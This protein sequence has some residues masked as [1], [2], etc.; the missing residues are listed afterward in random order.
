MKNNKI[1]KQGLVVVAT[2]T[3]LFGVSFVNAQTSTTTKHQGQK[4]LNQSTLVSK[5]N[6][7]IDKRVSDLTNLIGTLSSMKN[8]SSAEQSSLSGSIQSEISNLNNLKTKIAGDTD[9]TSLKNDVKSVTAD[10]RI[11]ALVIPQTRILAASDRATTVI[12]MITAMQTKLQSR[13]SDAQ[14][15]GK[16]VS[17]TTQ[18]LN[19]LGIKLAD[20]TNLNNSI[21][22]AISGL[23]PDQGNKTTLASN[24]AAL[25]AAR[26]N[27]TAIQSDLVAARKDIKT[28]M[29]DI[30]GVGSAAN[31]PA[32]ANIGTPSSSGTSSVNQ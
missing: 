17:N 5:A 10:N 18:S 29:S 24:T 30:K 8:I 28:I 12:N 23:T 31:T 11:Y 7:E 15:A 6:T 9:L 19:D 25:K 14:S 4:V 3:I 1:I 27:L 26:K 2:A 20:A 16:D 13:I 22:S 21:P 32:N